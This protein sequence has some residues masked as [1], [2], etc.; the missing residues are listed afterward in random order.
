MLAQ[1]EV[2]GAGDVK[3]AVEKRMGT[4]VMLLQEVRNWQGGQEV[5]PGFEFYTDLDDDIAV[6]IPWDY[7]CNVRECVFSRKYT[8]V[9][10]FWHQLGSVHLPC[11]GDVAL[12][13]LG[14]MMSEM[15]HVV[16][17]LRRRRHTSRIVIG[18]D[19]N[20]SLAPNLEGVDGSTNSSQ[21][22]WCIDSLARSGDRVDALT[23]SESC[24]H[25]KLRNLWLVK[26][27]GL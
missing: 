3:F 1:R 4:E 5:L 21:S 25:I 26:L 8:F 16:V 11:H 6:A 19:L 14:L 22:Y 27:L 7:A 12:D 23:P 2:D 13:D 15:E 20:V 10:M 18:C 17:N 24:V 9:V